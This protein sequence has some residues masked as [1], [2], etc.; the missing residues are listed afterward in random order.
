MSTNVA[1]FTQHDPSFTPALFSDHFGVQSISCPTSSNLG[2][3]LLPFP[4]SGFSPRWSQLGSDRC[5]QRDEFLS[6][7]LSAS[8]RR[9]SSAWVT[10]PGLLPTRP[11]VRHTSNTRSARSQR[12]P[13]GPCLS[14]PLYPFTSDL[15]CLWV[16]NQNQADCNRGEL[17]G[18]QMC[19]RGQRA[20]QVST[21]FCGKVES[22]NE[23]E[24]GLWGVKRMMMIDLNLS[25]TADIS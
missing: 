8:E 14:L 15:K 24:T 6:L 5:G 18:P 20:F 23:W 22:P 25:S 7:K 1:R 10:E 2:C 17:F 3:H 16:C 11:A 9:P 21:F 19:C 12:R 4:H 13:S